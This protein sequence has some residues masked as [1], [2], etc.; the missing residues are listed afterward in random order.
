MR[1][2]FQVGPYAFARLKKNAVRCYFFMNTSMMKVS[3]QIKCS[4]VPL[5]YEI[6]SGG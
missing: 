6:L 1:P 3:K 5:F 4:M 2:Y